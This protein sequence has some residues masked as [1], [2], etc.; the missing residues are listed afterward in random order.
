MVAKDRHEI[1]GLRRASAVTARL[2]RELVTLARPGVTTAE[3]N[4]HAVR[5]IQR[6]GGEAVFH[7]QNG[8][9]GA[10]NTSVNDEAVH[11]VPGPRRLQAGDLLKIDCGIR[12]NGYCGDTTATIIVGAPAGDVAE[13]RQ[14][15]EAARDALRLGIAAVR[16]GGH[17]GDIGQ[18][19]QTCVE[20]RGFRLLPEFTG[21][22]IGSRLWE[23]PSIPAVGR[24]G[25]GAPI[26]DGLTFTIEPIVT[27][28][29]GHVRLAPDGW[30]VL[31][32][33]GAPVAQFE[34]TVM[35]TTRGALVLTAQGVV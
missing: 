5:Y 35:A 1:D 32:V 2:L 4:A 30:T 22:G 3:L 14:V 28:G 31:T 21:H 8:F 34:H 33:D 13:R 16:V 29:S 26:V 25:S 6:V 23:R 17:V 15:L 9:P 12:L 11:G 10:I 7:T 27:S 20:G 19:M 24:A 18:A